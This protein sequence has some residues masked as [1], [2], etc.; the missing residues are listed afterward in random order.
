M[1]ELQC[2]LSQRRLL[3][4]F[5]ANFLFVKKGL[6]SQCLA[7]FSRGG[8]AASFLIS[9]RTHFPLSV[10]WCL[11]RR[12]QHHQDPPPSIFR[13]LGESLCITITFPACL[14]ASSSRRDAGGE[15]VLGEGW[16]VAQE[17]VQADGCRTSGCDGG[18][19]A[20]G[21]R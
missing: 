18:L 20:V 3:L 4:I 2:E 9:G 19:M 5:E 16:T 1:H 15:G 14:H 17:R 13:V 6:V 8:D 11:L 10:H 7:S 12:E 21:A